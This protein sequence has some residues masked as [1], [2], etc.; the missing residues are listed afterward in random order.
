MLSSRANNWFSPYLNHQ[1]PFVWPD[2]T[3]DNGN[4][5]VK[6][7]RDL[8]QIKAFP[9][10]VSSAFTECWMMAPGPR[11]R[12]RRKEVAATALVAGLPMETRGCDYLCGEERGGG[13][14]DKCQ[15]ETVG[16]WREESRPWEPSVWKTSSRQFSTLLTTINHLVIS[17][18]QAY[19]YCPQSRDFIKVYRIVIIA[20]KPALDLCT[21]PTVRQGNCRWEKKREN[22]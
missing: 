15:H 1:Q 13:A 12:L 17:R 4:G 2:N 3:I 8:Q 14:G 10:C 7:K 21:F 22:V 16:A 9:L 18:Q 19:F 6:Q 20:I 5:T 11:L